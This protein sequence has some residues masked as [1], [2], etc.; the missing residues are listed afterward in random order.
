MCRASAG[1]AESLRQVQDLP[2]HRDFRV[3]LVHCLFEILSDPCITN[4]VSRALEERQQ[5]L[6]LG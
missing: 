4:C 1:G 5:T 2:W 6:W 3:S